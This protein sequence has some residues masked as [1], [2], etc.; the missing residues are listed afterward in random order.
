MGKE[1][2]KKPK[3]WSK[4]PPRDPQETPGDPARKRPQGALKRHVQGH[5]GPSGTSQ[6]AKMGHMAPKGS[7]ALPLSIVLGGQKPRK[8][9]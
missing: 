9:L 6:G 8:V 5:Q 2:A 3:R 7:A 1:A 4:T